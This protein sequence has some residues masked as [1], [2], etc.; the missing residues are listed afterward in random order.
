MKVWFGAL[1]M[2]VAVLAQPAAADPRAFGPWAQ[3]QGQGRR[4]QPPR[5]PVQ[6]EQ[7]EP[8][9]EYQMPP[10]RDERPRGR[11]TDEE[12]RD[13][14]RDIDQANRDIYRRDRRR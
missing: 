13:L 1:M 5:G 6:H 12:R 9:R 4:A 11:L 10:Q 7:R 8:R 3:A 2:A 14:R